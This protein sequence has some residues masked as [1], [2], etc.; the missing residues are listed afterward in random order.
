MWEPNSTCL[1][2]S[3]VAFDLGHQIHHNTA[4]SHKDMREQVIQQA[5]VVLEGC[6]EYNEKMKMCCTL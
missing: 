2:H 5:E 1:K 6:Y 4:C 3:A